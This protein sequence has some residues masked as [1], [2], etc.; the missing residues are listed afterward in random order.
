MKKGCMYSMNQSVCVCVRVQTACVRLCNSDT[1]TVF[2]G[3]TEFL[4]G[5]KKRWQCSRQFCFCVSPPRQLVLVGKK[6]NEG[7][8]AKV[9]KIKAWQ[10]SKLLL[11]VSLL[12]VTAYDKTQKTTSFLDLKHFY[13]M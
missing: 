5:R 11:T 7:H 9:E 8:L 3:C 13:V 10:E 12:R 1:N 2:T 6:I 4:G